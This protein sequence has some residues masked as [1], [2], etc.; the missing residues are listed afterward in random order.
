VLVGAL[1]PDIDGH[2]LTA[3]PDGG[4]LPPA[5]V[6]VVHIY[7]GEQM[8]DPKLLRR[9][10]RVQTPT[11]VV[12]G[13]HDTFQTADFGRDYADAFPNARFVLIRD[14]GHSPHRDRP[15]ATLAAIQEFLAT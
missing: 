5:I 9:L 4:R 12:W 14:A 6:E 7:G 2:E 15:A 13:E 10:K 1:G 8:R 3:P 11:L